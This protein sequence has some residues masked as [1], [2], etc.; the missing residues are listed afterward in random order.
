MQPGSTTWR[1]SFS[2][3]AHI[4]FMPAARSASVVTRRDTPEALIDEIERG[5]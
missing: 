4:G 5:E 3:Q 1:T 2:K